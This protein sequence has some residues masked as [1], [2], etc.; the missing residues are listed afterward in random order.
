MW[1]L[2]K[3]RGH[4]VSK[5]S[6]ILDA[7]QAQLSLADLLAEIEVEESDG[8]TCEVEALCRRLRGVKIRCGFVMAGTAWGCPRRKR[9]LG[10]EPHK[11]GQTAVGGGQQ[12]G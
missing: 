11:V 8:H 10:P 7:D 12:N 5:L 3:Y 6:A 9:L 4:V 2:D 1:I